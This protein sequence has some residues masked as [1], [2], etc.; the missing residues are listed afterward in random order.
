MELSFQAKLL[1]A[2][3]EKEIVRIGSNK[4]LKTDCRILVATNRN[5][6]EDVKSGKFRKDLYYR[7]F[8]LPIELPPLRERDKDMLIL[9]KFFI[10]NFCEENEIGIKQL[11]ETARKK[12]MSYEFPG[13]IR[14]LKSVVELATALSETDTIEAHDLIF[15]SDDPLPEVMSEEL[16][17]R[18]YN[19]RIVKAYLQKFNDN[20]QDVA[21]KLDISVSTIYRML[22]EK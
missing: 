11:S 16:T 7:L 18:E 13:N 9:A 1:R 14:E 20:M 3:Q 17:L 10:S 6:R 2:I 19:L 12:L 22:K 8:G 4:A 21:D 5:M 15:G